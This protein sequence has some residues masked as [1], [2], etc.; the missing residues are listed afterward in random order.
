MFLGSPTKGGSDRCHVSFGQSSPDECNFSAAM[1][2]KKVMS[3]LRY[4]SDELDLQFQLCFCGVAVNLSEQIRVVSLLDPLVNF[5]LTFPMSAVYISNF[6]FWF[7]EMKTSRP[8][9]SSNSASAYLPQPIR[10]IFLPT[11]SAYT[12]PGEGELPYFR[13]INVRWFPC[14]KIISAN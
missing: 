10:R 2:L 11:Y 9:T 5:S 12:S 6:N 3:M 7:L 1:F 8:R 14:L 13:R 4:S